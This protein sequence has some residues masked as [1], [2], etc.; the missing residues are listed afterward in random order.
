MDNKQ[1]ISAKYANKL[2]VPEN[3][4]SVQVGVDGWGGWLGS[5]VKSP[6]G[7]FIGTA[8]THYAIVWNNLPGCSGKVV[9]YYNPLNGGKI[10]LVKGA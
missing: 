2:G 4:L 9:Y 3:E 1:R 8:Y 10:Y 5:W 6:I 7:K